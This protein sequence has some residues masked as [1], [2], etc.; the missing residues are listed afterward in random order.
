M[1]LFYKNFIYLSH[2]FL[3]M[4][5]YPE[6]EPI[7]CIKRWIFSVCDPKTLCSPL[8]VTQHVPLQQTFLQKYGTCVWWVQ[9][10]CA[11]LAGVWAQ[12]R[13]IQKLLFY[14]KIFN[15]IPILNIAFW[16]FIAIGIWTF[17]LNCLE[18][19]QI[20]DERY[21]HAVNQSQR[22]WWHRGRWRTGGIVCFS[23]KI[24]HQKR[25][26]PKFTVKW[27]QQP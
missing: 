8:P 24:I 15:W 14:K 7:I 12:T 27:K 6:A 20:N 21:R 19:R 26:L 2:I 1:F 22:G 18:T 5:K 25:M 3:W 17:N 16:R 10:I 13:N 4:R 9:I 23:W 11:H